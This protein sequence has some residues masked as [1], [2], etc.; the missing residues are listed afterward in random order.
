MMYGSQETGLEKFLKE[1]EGQD[2]RVPGIG[3]LNGVNKCAQTRRGQWGGFDQKMILG[4]RFHPEGTG[5]SQ[6][7]LM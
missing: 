1:D 2:G 3:E 6:H 5:Y 7:I 4:L